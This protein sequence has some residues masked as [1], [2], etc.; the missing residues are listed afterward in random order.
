M[1]ST[2]GDQLSTPPPARDAIGPKAGQA[3]PPKNAGTSRKDKIN[4][5]SFHRDKIKI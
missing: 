5:L 2:S 1:P 3:Q 4:Y